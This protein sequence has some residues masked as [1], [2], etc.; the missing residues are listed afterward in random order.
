LHFHRWNVMKY[1]SPLVGSVLLVV[2]PLLTVLARRG[3]HDEREAAEL[4]R[5]NAALQERV[6]VLQA[7]VAASESGG[8]DVERER[9]EFLATLSHELRSPLNAIVGW[10]ELLR[11]HANDPARQAHAL[12]VIE[13][14]AHAQMRIVSDLLDAGRLATRRLEIA[15]APVALQEVVD[16]AVAAVKDAAAARGITL[17]VTRTAAPSTTG[18]RAR[19][20]QALV[21]LLD[22][23]LKFTDRGGEVTITLAQD[24]AHAV[25]QVTDT[26]IGIAADV[27]PVVFDRFRQGER[28]LTRR[29]GGLG[30][31]LTIVQ[32]LVELHGGTVEAGSAGAGRGATFTVRLP[33]RAGA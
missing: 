30:L 9:D 25:V 7:Q 10:L 4:R 17:L 31:G 16:D 1:P 22:N 5:A 12:D 20:R 21:H 19:L 23:A 33:L 29:Y 32:R 26:G 13:R 24:H 28:G 3:R 6:A 27:L 14:N 15:R 18:D 11:L 2:A 8:S